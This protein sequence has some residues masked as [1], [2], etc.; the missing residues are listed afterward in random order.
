ML[1]LK[2]L[3]SGPSPDLSFLPSSVGIHPPLL[4]IASSQ[5]S[6]IPGLTGVCNPELLIVVLSRSS[7]WLFPSGS[8]ES[9]FSWMEIKKELPDAEIHLIVLVAIFSQP[10][11]PTA[12]NKGSF[13]PPSSL[14]GSGSQGG[15]L[16]PQS[17][18]HPGYFSGTDEQTARTV[19]PSL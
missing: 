11:R 7:C 9:D 10:S 1:N 17:L 19:F 12:S 2:L 14:R 18:E 15:C 5:F 8:S 13:L 4:V 6:F 16:N 3:C